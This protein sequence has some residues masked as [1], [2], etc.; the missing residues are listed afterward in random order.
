MA[1]SKKPHRFK[2]KKPIYKNRFLGIITGSLLVLVILIYLIS[3]G[4]WFQIERMEI[5]GN[6]EVKTKV[7]RKTVAES[8]SR[9]FIVAD[10]HSIFLMNTAQAKAKLLAQNPGLKQVNFKRNY[11]NKLIITVTERK[12]VAIFVYQGQ[13]YL[14][15][16][17]GII[18][19]KGA[20]AKTNFEFKNLKLKNQPKL[21][22]QV[23]DKEIFAQLL[24]INSELKS[25]NVSNAVLVSDSQLNLEVTQGWEI[26]F[27]LNKD[28]DWQLTRLKSVLR[29]TPKSQ[30]EQH[31]DL[32]FGKVF[33]K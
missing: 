32:R 29:K 6:R 30:I 25:V 18:F 28:F 21:G 24:T 14:M 12:P 33:V 11:P 20:D 22:Q 10:S 8:I 26:Y 16:A 1:S 4:P 9:S 31:I 2:R 13:K 17:E 15:G 27:G 19:E 7:I 5:S 3:F 23:V